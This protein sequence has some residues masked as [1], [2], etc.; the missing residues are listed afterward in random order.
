MNESRGVVGMHSISAGCR[1]KIPTI[2][3]QLNFLLEAVQKMS[4]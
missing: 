4:F 3:K 2:K 1:Q